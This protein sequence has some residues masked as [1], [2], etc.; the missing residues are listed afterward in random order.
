MTLRGRIC[1]VV[2]LLA[3]SSCSTAVDMGGGVSRRGDH[4]FFSKGPE[5]DATVSTYLVDQALGEKWIVLAA[6]F[7]ATGGVLTIHRDAVALR[8]P[9][10]RLLPLLS[11]E[12]FRAVYGEIRFRVR[13]TQLSAASSR[14]YAGD[15]ESIRV[16]D[17]W[18]FAE[19]AAGFATDEVRVTN[20]D[21]CSGPL[22]FS[23]PGGIQPG[24]WRLVID[25]EE[26]T[27]DIPFEVDD[28]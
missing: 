25:L 19:P 4:L 23:V 28:R 15:P 27:A 14:A 5:L 26:S 11:Q 3:V 7:K 18:F 8:T 9:D 17:R 6:S 2:L 20:F 13:R 16:C 1:A 10:G 12:E 22:V 21:I 24:R